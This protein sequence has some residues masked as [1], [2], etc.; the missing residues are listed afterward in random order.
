MVGEVIDC[1]ET[2]FGCAEKRPVHDRNEEHFSSVYNAGVK[3]VLS[4][5]RFGHK[6]RQ[7]NC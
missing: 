1:N 2:F 3:S 7:H 5:G 4:A 6:I